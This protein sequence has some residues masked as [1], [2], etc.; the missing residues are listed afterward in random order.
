LGRTTESKREKLSRAFLERQ[1][2]IDMEKNDAV[3]LE[4]RGE[5]EIEEMGSGSE[6]EEEVEE[7]EETN[8]HHTTDAKEKE[9]ENKEAPVK[10]PLV[11]FGSGLK[12]PLEVDEE[13]KPIIK[14]RKRT[15]TR[16]V[17]M[18]V[19]QEPEWEGF[20]S[21]DEEMA[22]ES[23]S[24]DAPEL[25]D[26][27]HEDGVEEKSESGGNGSPSEGDDDSED[28]EDSDEEMSSEDDEMKANR[29]ERTS[30]FKAWATQQRHE[31][32]GF[33]PSSI[34]TETP[35]K[36]INFTPRAPESDPLPP[37]LQ[38][39]TTTD[40]TRK[41]FSVHIERPPEIQDAR[42]ALPIVAEEQKIMEAIHNNDVVV[43]WGATGSGKTTQVPQ[44]LYESGYGAP[45]GPTPGLIG[46]TQPR[47][48]AAVSMSKRVG[49]E[50]G[51]AGS[52]VSY[53]V[54]LRCTR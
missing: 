27:D 4:K 12:R 24:E 54:S 14:K 1:A 20:N 7:K 50:L 49:D 22:T 51:H 6:S 35:T 23:E 52:K 33:T 46:V 8:G 38:S 15:K 37:E 18:P 3:L 21:E 13:G 11:G 32:I 19:Y 25:Q 40:A 30:A 45:D 28:E 53:Q 17:I 2:G 5:R 39:N 42:L 26:S 43:V 10:K 41:A 48:V 36:P 31:A 9:E 29:K 34:V 47:R 44:F 16:S